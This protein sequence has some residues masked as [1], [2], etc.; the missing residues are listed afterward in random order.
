MAVYEIFQHTQQQ[1]KIIQFSIHLRFINLQKN[2]SIIKGIQ[3]EVNRLI[4][5]SNSFP[6]L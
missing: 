5:I 1:S 6:L 3:F 4:K 2:I